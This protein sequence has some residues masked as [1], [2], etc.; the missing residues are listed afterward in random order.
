MKPTLTVI[1]LLLLPFLSFGQRLQSGYYDGSLYLAADTLHHQLTGYFSQSSGWDESLKVPMFSCVFYLK[2]DLD[3]DS[4]ALTTYYP[5]EEKSDLIKG[6]LVIKNDHALTIQLDEDHGGC[7]NVQNFKPEP[8]P[9]QLEQAS[10]WTSIRYVQSPKAYFYA[11]KSNNKK[12]K[13]YVVQNDFICIER[14]DNEWAYGY[15]FGDK[16]TSGWLRLS[17]LN[18]P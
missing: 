12:R 11:E 2:G 5:D 8:I 14:I 3:K 18:I 4:I 16:T 1:L 17:D 10:N 6:W 9:F 15:F 7:G 13:A